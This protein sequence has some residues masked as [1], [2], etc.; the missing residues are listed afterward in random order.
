[1]EMEA[2]GFVTE[3]NRREQEALQVLELNTGFDTVYWYQNRVLTKIEQDKYGC[4]ID[5]DGI[6]DALEIPADSN[7]K[8][9]RIPLSFK[10]AV[11]QGKNFRVTICIDG[12][13]CGI[14]DCLIYLGRRRLAY[15]GTIE[16]G[17]VYKQTFTVNNCDIIPRG[18]ERIYVD[19]SLDITIIGDRPSISELHIE[20]ENC[21]TLYIAGDSTVTDQTADYPYAPESSYSGWGQMLSA[22]LKP[23]IALSNHAH[24]G[25]TTESFRKEGHYSIVEQYL[26]PGDYFFLQ[27]AHND[28]KLDH[29]KAKEGYRN[30]VIRYLDEIRSKGAIPVIVTPLA[31]NTWKGADGTYNDLLK[32]YAECCI[33]IGK[34]YEVPVVDLHKYS[35]EYVMEKGL[36]AAKSIFFPGDYTHTN[37]YGAYLMAGYVAM[38]LDRISKE[39]KDAAYKQLG[40][41]VTDGCG[42]WMAPEKIALP[43]VPTDLA[44]LANPNQAAVLF[45][46]LERPEDT[47][48]RVEALDMIIQTAHFFPT[49]VY[50][51][52]FTDVVG[53]EWFAGTVE[54]AYQ[55]GIIIPEMVKDGCF[56]PLKQMTLE[57]FLVFAMNGYRS[58]KAMPDDVSCPYDSVVSEYTRLFVRAAYHIGVIEDEEQ[59][60]APCTRAKAAE[61]C[62][63]MK[64]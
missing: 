45:S 44:D 17:T 46:E 41:F 39:H 40:Q 12:T 33:E 18:K 6:V 1:M 43:E 62:R 19:K 2:Y 47:V 27:F 56:E 28:Q 50:N 31:R 9:R 21:P 61:I 5:S 14:E 52:M 63:K 4:F 36:E 51:D 37:D 64:I 15:K 23:G 20:E 32:E 29:L 13:E 34:E 10:V 16:K 38:E 30:N 22:Y 25:L 3:E 53:H 59:M 58:R 42:C 48:I 8:K 26:K 11:P 57:E 55:N 24:S 35:M 7:G 54:C 60:K 49:N